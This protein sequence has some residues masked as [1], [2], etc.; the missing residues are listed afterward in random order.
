MHNMAKQSFSPTFS[1]YRYTTIQLKSHTYIITT[2]ITRMKPDVPRHNCWVYIMPYN[3]A[4]TS[5]SLKYLRE[6]R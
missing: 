6:S 1:N 3:I 4:Y 5:V 2:I